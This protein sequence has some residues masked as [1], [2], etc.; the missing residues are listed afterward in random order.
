LVRRRVG[1]GGR[2][3]QREQLVAG[4][5]DHALGHVRDGGQGG[6]VARHA[7]HHLAQHRIVQDPASR[8]VARHGAPLAP[9]GERAQQP[10]AS[11]VPALDAAEPQPSAV[12]VDRGHIQGFE[13]CKLLGEPSAP[14]QAVELAEQQFAQ[15]Q[16]M[17]DIVERV[18]D[19]RLAQGTARPIGAR[20]ALGHFPVE[21]APHQLGVA[22]LGGM[23]GQGGGDLGVSNSG[24]TGPSSGASTSRSCR[25]ACSTFAGPAAPSATPSGRRSS[26]ASGS[27]QTGPRRVVSC[28][29][30]S[31]AR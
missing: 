11:L 2:L 5:F 30:H 22:H 9:G 15:R 4:M 18:L 10:Q 3:D 28:S 14:P 21:Q 29:R 7:R 25:P 1:H 27:T 19:L 8:L 16:Q 17:P 23:A 20:L 24:A 13:R 12:G 6:A 31:S 26:S